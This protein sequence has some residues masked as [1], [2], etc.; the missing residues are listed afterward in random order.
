MFKIS[1][2]IFHRRKKD[3]HVWND[4]RVNKVGQDLDFIHLKLIGPSQ[5]TTGRSDDLRDLKRWAHGQ[6]EKQF[7][8]HFT[9]VTRLI[10]E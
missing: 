9:F 1:S 10:F 6:H 2:F 5:L 7:I 4:I 3:I 8:T